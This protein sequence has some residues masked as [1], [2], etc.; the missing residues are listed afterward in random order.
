MEFT[1]HLSWMKL[2]NN[3]AISANRAAN[4]LISMAKNSGTLLY[5]VFT[6]GHIY[7]L[8]IIEYSSSLWGHMSYMQ[9]NINIYNLK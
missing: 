5:D 2:I 6:H 3:V 8:L 9:I 7:V 1:E 4:Y